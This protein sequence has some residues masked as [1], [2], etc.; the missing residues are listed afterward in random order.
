MNRDVEIY[1]VKNRHSEEL[2]SLS[3]VSG[4]GVA[5]G[6]GGGLVITVYVDRDDA[7]VTESLPKEIEGYPVEA[8]QSGPFTKL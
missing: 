2:R 6:K 7:K 4:V 1:E 8:V 3:G 5:K